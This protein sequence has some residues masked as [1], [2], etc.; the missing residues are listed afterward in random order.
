MLV[1]ALFEEGL[2]YGLGASKADFVPKHQLSKKMITF[3]MWGGS[4]SKASSI[5]SRKTL[6]GVMLSYSHFLR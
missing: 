3:F 1:A 6:E 2:E 5:F 4:P